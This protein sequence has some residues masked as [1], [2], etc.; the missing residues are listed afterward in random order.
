MSYLL[1]S[2]T[3][4]TEFA[5]EVNSATATDQSVSSVNFSEKATYSVAAPEASE[6]SDAP[7]VEPCL[8][9]KNEYRPLISLE[10]SMPDDSES[11]VKHPRSHYE[12]LFYSSMKATALSTLQMCRA[13]YEAQ[14]ALDSFEFKKF[15]K[16]INQSDASSTIRKYI[17]IGK[18]Y[19]RL[20]LYADQ[21]ARGW[22]TIYQ[23]TQIPA[24]TFDEMIKNEV[25]L[26]TLRGKN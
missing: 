10:R 8:M 9:P 1:N 6:I 21:L 2:E 25:S 24:H 22:T 23:I 17:A 14:I 12:A 7:I 3:T 13:V 16:S 11:I 26:S 20:V 5:E 19:P 4:S 18:A 15:C